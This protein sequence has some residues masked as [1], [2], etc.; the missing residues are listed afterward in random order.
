MMG[1]TC[2]KQSWSLQRSPWSTDMCKH[3]EYSVT[4]NP[5]WIGQGLQGA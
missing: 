3:Q 2:S 1:P 5:G 4:L